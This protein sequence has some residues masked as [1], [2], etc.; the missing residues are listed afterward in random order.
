MKRPIGDGCMLL[1]LV[2][3]VEEDADYVTLNHDQ[4]HTWVVLFNFCFWAEIFAKYS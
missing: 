3:R 2:L 1:Y 4:V